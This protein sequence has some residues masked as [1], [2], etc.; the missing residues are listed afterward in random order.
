M[1]YKTCKVFIYYVI[2]TSSQIK[3]QRKQYYHSC[4]TYNS[5]VDIK[6]EVIN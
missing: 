6:L 4:N 3:G 1:S 5:R 2:T